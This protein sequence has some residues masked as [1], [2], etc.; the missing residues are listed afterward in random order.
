[1]TEPA[2]QVDPVVPSGGFSEGVSP[3]GQVLNELSDFNARFIYHPNKEAHDTIALWIA[4]TYYM[5][6]WMYHPR[7]Y[8][9]SPQAGTG[10]STQGTIIESLALNGEKPSNVTSAYIWGRVNETQ[11]KVTI[12]IDESDNIWAKGRD[13]TDLQGILNDGFQYGAQVGRALATDDGISTKRYDSYCP[14][15]IIGIKNSRIPDTLMSRSIK[16]DMKLPPEGVELDWFDVFDH[17][18]FIKHIQDELAKVE[19]P[20]RLKLDGP[21]HL[22]MRSF[23]QV[24]LPMFALAEVAGGDWPQ[25]A[26]NASVALSGSRTNG[27]MSNTTRVLL[28]V[29]DYFIEN[30]TEKIQPAVLAEELGKQD[31]FWQMDAQRLAYFLKPYELV[32]KPSNGKKWFYREDVLSTV[33]TWQPD[34]YNRGM[35][36]ENPPL[37]TT[38]ATD[39]NDQAT[40]PDKGRTIFDS[41]T[42]KSMMTNDNLSGQTVTWGKDGPEW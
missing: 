11:G 38:G 1:M 18:D 19:V 3:L 14:I 28:A 23:R 37:G 30:K 4:S 21:S 40:K 22:G 8:I 13:T 35:G 24:W 34:H 29:F 25:R 12:L 32:S 15:G 9:S 41:P 42:V 6:Q 5:P 17:E 16:I 7:I 36:Y 31:D 20:H 33:K 27:A 10:K 2:R 26:Y 39:P